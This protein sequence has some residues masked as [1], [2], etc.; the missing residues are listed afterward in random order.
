MKYENFPEKAND[1]LTAAAAA[2][3]WKIAKKVKFISFVDAKNSLNTV[4]PPPPP[5]FTIL[6]R[7]SL[8]F[9]THTNFY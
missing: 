3:V 9:I 1:V 8:A 7:F 4:M 5:P 6:C 2:A